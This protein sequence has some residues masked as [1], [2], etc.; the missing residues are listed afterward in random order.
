MR[1]RPSPRNGHK[2]FRR[3]AA[4]LHAILEQMSDQDLADVVACSP[5]LSNTNC[6]WDEY[7]LRMALP[8]IAE[9]HIESRK[10]RAAEAAAVDKSRPEQEKP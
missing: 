2:Q 6:G 1:Q 10:A 7:A 9:G 4:M 5:M 3:V 8:R